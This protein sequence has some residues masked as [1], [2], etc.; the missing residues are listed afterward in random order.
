MTFSDK[1][2][3]EENEEKLKKRLGKTQFYIF[4]FS[5]SVLI[6]ME[7]PGLFMRTLARLPNSATKFTSSTSITSHYH[8]I[9]IIVVVVLFLRHSWNDKQ[10]SREETIRELKSYVKL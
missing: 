1:K 8:L 9:V 7:S 4:Y 5:L 3:T 2:K 6:Q 10:E